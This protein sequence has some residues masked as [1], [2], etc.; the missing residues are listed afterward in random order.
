MSA[1]EHVFCDSTHAINLA[2][3]GRWRQTLFMLQHDKFLGT[4]PTTIQ[5]KTRILKNPIIPYK[6][7]SSEQSHVALQQH[8]T[9]NRH[10]PTCSLVHP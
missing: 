3:S 5:G 7:V 4:L 2:T 1:H 6:E 9:T 8:K 10:L